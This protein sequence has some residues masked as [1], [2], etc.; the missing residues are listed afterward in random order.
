MQVAVAS[1]VS[2][3]LAVGLFSMFVKRTRC[4]GFNFF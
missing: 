4:D 1:K 3:G 2:I